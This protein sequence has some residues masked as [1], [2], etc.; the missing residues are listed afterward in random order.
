MARHISNY[1]LD[2]AQFWR[3]PVLWCTQWKGTSQDCIDH[4]RVQHHIKTANLGK[5][6]PPW[7]VTRADWNTAVKSNV[8]GIST[9]VVLFSKHGASWSTT[10]GCSGG[11]V[12]HASLFGSFMIHLFVILLGFSYH[13]CSK[14]NT[15]KVT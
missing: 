3:R 7:T 10:T 15:L 11:C 1:Q 12:A 13:S 9:D 6:F 5:W 4:I 2:L 14:H 8:S